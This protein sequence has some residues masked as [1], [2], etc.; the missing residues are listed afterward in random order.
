ML[1][2][3]RLC[4]FFVRM[5]FSCAEKA[6][7]KPLVLCLILGFAAVSCAGVQPQPLAWPTQTPSEMRWHA[8]E[9]LA[10]RQGWTVELA[11]LKT[12]TLVAYTATAGVKGIRDRIDVRLLAGSTLVATSSEVEDGE[13]WLGSS[14]RCSGYTFSREREVAISIEPRS[15]PPGEIHHR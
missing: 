15:K 12:R 4:S 2:W 14:E 3:H 10:K 7:R 8:L 9:M 6:C 1:A 13:E 5:T 11:D